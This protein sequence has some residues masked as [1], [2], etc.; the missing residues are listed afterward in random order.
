MSTCSPSG[1]IEVIKRV[2]NHDEGKGTSCDSNSQISEAFW[3][4][5][6]ALRQ[7]PPGSIWFRLLHEMVL[8]IMVER[9]ISLKNELKG[10]RRNA[11]SNCLNLHE[12]PS[13]NIPSQSSS[14]LSESSGREAGDQ[15]FMPSGANESPQKRRSASAT[16]SNNAAMILPM[17]ASVAEI[18]HKPIPAPMESSESLP[19]R[20]RLF[21][22]SSQTY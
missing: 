21:R 6:E 19:R 13:P 14:Q 9:M 17:A 4:G 22:C 2:V 20:M 18:A 16:V 15:G 3:K 7:I 1:L 5:P 12:P 11:G 8:R 10:Y